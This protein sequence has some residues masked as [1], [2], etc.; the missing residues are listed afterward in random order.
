MKRFLVIATAIVL[1][2]H[3]PASADLSVHFLYVGQGDCTILSV[4]I[5]DT[6]IRILKY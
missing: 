2:I 3:T 6:V 1:V 4:R 5:T